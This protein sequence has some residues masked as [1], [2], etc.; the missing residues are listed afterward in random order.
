MAEKLNDLETENTKMEDEKSMTSDQE[1]PR[2]KS[3]SPVRLKKTS[4]PK[5]R[6][7]DWPKK[8]FYELTCFDGADKMVHTDN[9]SIEAWI[10]DLWNIL[11]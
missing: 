11:L 1:K 9:H 3:K 2:T 7:W 6:V 5:E 4:K 8:S 10:Y